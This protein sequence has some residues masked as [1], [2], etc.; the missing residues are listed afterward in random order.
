MPPNQSLETTAVSAL[1]VNKKQLIY[2]L[3]CNATG[4]HKLDPLIIGNAQ[5]PQAFRQ[6]NSSH[7]GFNYYFNQTAWMTTLIFTEWL[8]K[9]NGYFQRQKRKI[10]LLLDNLSG[11]VNS[12]ELTDLTNIKIHF[13][14]PNL[15]SIIQPC[16]SGIIKKCKAHY[17][18]SF[19]QLAFS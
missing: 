18:A 14:P 8:K 13:F 9:I 16:S 11:H 19:L 1:E 17:Q 7:W 5:R 6:N 10:L 15:T 12:A 2:L 4:T 3:A